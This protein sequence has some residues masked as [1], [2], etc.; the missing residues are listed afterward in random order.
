VNRKSFDV[1][2]EAFHDWI[3]RND[4]HEVTTK[5]QRLWYK[6]RVSSPQYKELMQIAWKRGHDEA[7]AER[8]TQEK[9]T[10]YAEGGRQ[11]EQLR[12]WQTEEAK[13]CQMPHWLHTRK[14]KAFFR[15]YNP[16]QLWEP[17]GSTPALVPP[18]GYPTRSQGRPKPSPP[19]PRYLSCPQRQPNEGN[20]V[21]KELQDKNSACKPKLHVV[22]HNIHNCNFL[23]G[24]TKTHRRS[25]TIRMGEAHA[26]GHS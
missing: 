20:R 12:K 21:R 19:P 9:A 14:P 10:L 1:D 17:R 26:A 5:K 23:G 16:N 2:L 11:E 4:L 18:S 8:E 13:H 6:Q 7:E 22:S 25:K 15:L 3:E 24:I